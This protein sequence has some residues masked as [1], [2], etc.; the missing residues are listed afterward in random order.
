[1]KQ[2]ATKTPSNTKLMLAKMDFNGNFICASKDT[3]ENGLFK[4]TP[5]SL[6][7]TRIILTDG[8]RMTTKS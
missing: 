8:Y 1:M 6:E 2:P 5:S 7:Q 3:Y 4:P